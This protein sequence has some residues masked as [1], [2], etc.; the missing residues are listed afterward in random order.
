VF[1]DGGTFIKAPVNEGEASGIIYGNDG[2]AN[3]NK[4]T[5]GE[6]SFLNDKGHAVYISATQR[7]E[8]TVLP[9]TTLDSTVPGADGGWVD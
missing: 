7:R 1:V 2:T 8:S 4:A 3:R 9:D 6:T 5:Q